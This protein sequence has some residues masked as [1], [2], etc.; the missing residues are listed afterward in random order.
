MKQRPLGG[1]RNFSYG[2]VPPVRAIRQRSV[3]QL[4]PGAP[5]K[6]QLYLQDRSAT[7]RLADCVNDR[8]VA[9]TVISRSENY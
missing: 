8:D 3:G 2:S 9:D 6:G 7:R 1:Q 5:G 4:H